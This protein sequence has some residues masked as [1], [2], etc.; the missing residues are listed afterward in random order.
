LPLL[1]RLLSNWAAEPATGPPPGESI[2][3]SIYPAELD[4]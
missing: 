4:E 2:T 1:E 3:A